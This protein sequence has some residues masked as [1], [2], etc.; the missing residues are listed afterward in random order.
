MVSNKTKK[1][2]CIAVALSLIANLSTQ[3][4]ASDLVAIPQ[5]N[6]LVVIPPN[7]SIIQHH[8]TKFSMKSIEDKM[9]NILKPT[10]KVEANKVNRKVLVDD[11]SDSCGDGVTYK[12]TASTGE[13]K[14]SGNG[15]MTN[16]SNSS[17][18]PWYSYIN[19]IK[20]VTIGNGVTS[21]G[22]N[23][24]D[25]CDSLTSVTIP[26]SVTSIEYE[27]F[28]YCDNLT[29]VTIGSGVISINYDAFYY[30]KSL[31]LIEVDTNNEN[32]KSIDGILYSKDSKT[33]IMCPEGISG[34]FTIPSSV[35]SI[36]RNAF[37]MCSKLTSVTIPNSVTSI[38]QSAFS[39]C[40]CLKSVTLFYG[41]TSI[42][43]YVFANCNSLTSITIPNSV[44]SIGWCAFQGCESLTLVTIPNS[45]TSIDVAAF[46]L[47][48]SLTSIT[49]P[50]SVI[51]IGNRAFDDCTGLTSV[52]YTGITEP[53]HG[54]FVFSSYPKV[55]V[56]NRYKKDTFCGIN[57]NK[58]L[59]IVPLCTD[60]KDQYF[61]SNAKK[62]IVCKKHTNICKCHHRNFM[63]LNLRFI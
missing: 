48:K 53:K 19:Y 46:W 5:N 6:T 23:A 10:K 61:D 26:N 43:K 21:I 51:S 35:T 58:S 15:A 38:G 56:S 41:I 44:T 40:S 20:S 47:C 17:S 18:V 8:S 55:E 32:Y 37:H 34:S 39:N 33:L 36:G 16:Y 22:S 12:F 13:L 31:T 25:S 24:F 1:A 3:V 50:K 49:I 59:S 11:D 52:T 30:S 42:N 27:A 45:V 7:S 54:E 60:G 63:L 2:I 29:S 14:I 57:V 62:I 9:S 28:A 4:H